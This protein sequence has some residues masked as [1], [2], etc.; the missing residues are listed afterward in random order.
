MGRLFEIDFW[1]RFGM[2]DPDNLM[3]LWQNEEQ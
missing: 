2:G 1:E 3:F